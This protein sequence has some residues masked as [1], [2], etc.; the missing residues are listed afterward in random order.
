MNRVASL[1][2]QT[3]ETS[4][5]LAVDLD[6]T[7]TTAI[8]TGLGFLDHMLTALSLHSRIDIELTC[9]GDRHVDDHHTVEDCALAL[10]GAIA[11]A[12]GDRT[13]IT[14]FGWAFA[15]LDESLA[16]AVI[17]LSGRPASVIDLG[18]TREM[19]GE[20][21]CENITHFFV[22]LAN[23]LGAAIHIDVLRGKNDHHMAEAAFK[24]CALALRQAVRRDGETIPSTK[25]TLR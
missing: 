25:G 20:V 13:G 15:P 16:R 7:G 17:D 6:G 23:T 21:A 1:S 4:V 2:R 24:A 9:E 22:S 11:E 8:N 12:L 10:G 5:Q 3:R 14:R 18:L 19:L